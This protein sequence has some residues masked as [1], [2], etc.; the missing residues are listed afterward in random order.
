MDSAGVGL[1]RGGLGEAFAGGRISW[2]AGLDGAGLGGA[3]LVE[4]GLAGA[5]LAGVGWG[6]GA[7]GAS[8]FSADG[9][10]LEDF[11]GA[12]FGM[13]SSEDPGIRSRPQKGHF[14]ELSGIFFRHW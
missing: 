5:G 3:V 8:G 12:D 10:A 13:V 9:L 14:R 2:E 11:S 7:F 4:A 6:G 1:D